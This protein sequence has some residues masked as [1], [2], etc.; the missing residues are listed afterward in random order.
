MNGIDFED[1]R[2][3]A[4]EK[5]TKQFESAKLSQALEDLTRKYL[6]LT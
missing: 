5:C 2:K 4:F 6:D 3:N 1:I